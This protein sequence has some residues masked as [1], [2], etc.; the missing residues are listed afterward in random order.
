MSFLENIG[1]N[2]FKQSEESNTLVDNKQI[3][4]LANIL[5]NIFC[6]DTF[7]IDI[8]KLVVI[9]TQSSGKS[10]LLNSIIG[11]DIL[12]TG[13]SMVTRV[14]LN[15]EL[16]NGNK[17]FAEFGKY[18][19]NMWI[20]SKTIP[21]DYPTPLKDQQKQ[22]NNE[23]VRYTNLYAGDQQNINSTAINLRIYS[24]YVT[25]IN[26]VDLP[27]LT[28]IACTDKGQPHDIKQQIQDLIASYISKE[29]S[30]IIAAM[31]ARSDLE[32]DMTFE[33]I[34]KYDPKG[35]RSI[36]V[37]TKVDLMN[38]DNNIGNYLINNE[39][40][41]DL[42]LKLGYYAVKGK[43]DTDL[44]K[45]IG[46]MDV[47]KDYFDNH[48]VYKHSIY[49]KRIGIKNLSTDLANI[50]IQ[51]LKTYLPNILTELNE[52]LSDVNNK[53][54]QMGCHIEN[55][56][57]SK[58]D[59]S[60]ILNMFITTY[61]NAL[62]Q[63][64]STYNSGRKIKGTFN[65]F[66]NKVEK[67]KPYQKQYFSDEQIIN[68]LENCDGNHMSFPVPSIDIIEACLLDKNYNSFKLLNEP[69]IFCNEDIKKILISLIDE[70]LESYTYKRYPN[71]VKVI[72][73]VMLN[74]IIS[75]CSENTSKMLISFI[76]IEENYIWTD[77]LEFNQSVI[78]FV[79]NSAK[80][81]NIDTECFREILNTYYKTVTT[82][83]KNTIP[84]YIMYYNVN[85]CCK[86]MSRKLYTLVTKNENNKDK[87]LEE[88]QEV[89]TERTKLLNKRG[90][91][92]EAK[93]S[94]EDFF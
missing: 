9:G 4:K 79:Q 74:D 26:L 60:S 72:K 21:F 53:L 78:K 19:S 52:S 31:P 68:F 85:E 93:E 34:K 88:T 62:T 15:L 55:D 59:L 94:I 61:K 82:N 14:P 58:P 40:S 43:T 92:I 17:N 24:P 65:D 50:L 54:S 49:K 80:S 25:N 46:I 2:Y 6:D 51:S 47:E 36:G 45:G 39:I 75:F 37:L 66:R 16:I 22:I 77:D 23:I 13:K 42:Q 57:I 91:L 73:S 32:T 35:E 70:V 69:T 63:R 84:K 71:L 29:S 27:G 67:I 76:N 3:L 11:S 90:K 28:S 83:I 89:V 33:M 8:P 7:D 81:T 44:Q 5:N 10:S 12:P 38:N 87:L 41:K 86:L 30:I 1:I 56:E 48:P 64:G 20:A 18:Q